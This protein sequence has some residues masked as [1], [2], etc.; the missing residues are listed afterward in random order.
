V[1]VAD[2]TWNVRM[3]PSM[4]TLQAMRSAVPEMVLLSGV[5]SSLLVASAIYLAGRARSSELTIRRTNS[6]LLDEITQRRIT[7]QALRQTALRLEQS[8]REL[9]DFASVA[10]HDLQEPLRKIQAFGDRL[11]QK[12]ALELG[13]DGRDYLS[14]M[15][16]A[17]GRMQSLINDLLS[18]SRVTT[19]AQPFAP[20]ELADVVSEVQSDLEARL[21]QTGGAIE[22][23]PLPLIHADALQMRQ[24]MQNLISNALKFH[25][26]GEPPRVKVFA[27]VES[28]SDAQARQ[29]GR[30]F[31]RIHVQDFGIGFDEKYLD[32][33][34]SVFQRLHGRG[35]YEGTGIGLA[36]CRKIAERHH[37]SITAR[38]VPGQGATFIVTLPLNP[39]H[40]VQKASYP[41]PAE[42]SA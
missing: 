2:R 13:D 30:G 36:V 29:N 16:A 39:E 10:S 37:G 4:A 28:I 23:G 35:E 3:W 42:M 20:V 14:R 38:S 21:E 9:Q 26:P 6:E 19:K 32:R 33:I 17:A 25:R 27:E 40:V 31:V 15:Q 11:R 34:F 12:R 22:V 5:V 18:F 7:E 8:N 41:A 1:Q 24:L